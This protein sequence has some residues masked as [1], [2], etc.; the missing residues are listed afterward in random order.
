MHESPAGTRISG[1]R[2]EKPSDA[3]SDEELIRRALFRVS[4]FRVPPETVD[5]FVRE[6]EDLSFAYQRRA[7]VAPVPRPR[8]L[9]LVKGGGR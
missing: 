5:E 8:S 6:V 9:K 4:Y 7:R 1:A 3:P 2:S